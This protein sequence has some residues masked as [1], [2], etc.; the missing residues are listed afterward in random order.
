M[1]NKAGIKIISS[2]IFTDHLYKRHIVCRNTTDSIVTLTKNMKL[3][4]LKQDCNSTQN[5]TNIINNSK[6][7][8][9][10]DIKKSSPMDF[11]VPHLSKK[12]QNKI[13]TILEGKS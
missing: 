2:N 8:N 10:K 4:Q 3:A 5:E 6:H 12:I 7:I 13:L 9:I 11:E 1:H